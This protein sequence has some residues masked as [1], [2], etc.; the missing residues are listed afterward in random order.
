MAV[1]RRTLLLGG[2][3]IGIGIPAALHLRWSSK[4]FTRPGYSDAPPPAGS[5][6][7][8]SGLQT[9][10]PKAMPVA[11][12]AADLARIV[13][14]SPAPIRAVGSGHS[15]APLVPSD[16]TIVDI[17]PLAGVLSREQGK[18]TVR[19]AAGTRLAQA[20][21]ELDALGLAFPNLPDIDTQTLAG[22]FATGTHGTGKTLPALH[23]AIRGCTLVT[24]KG[25]T[26]TLSER[27]NAELLPAA[28]V[29]LGSLGIA[30]AFDVELVD[31]FSLNRKV[32][33][34]PLETLLAKAPDLWATHRN[35]EFY[36]LP[37]TGRV[38]GIAH[39]IVTGPAKGAKADD[40]DETL[41]GLK[42]MR[43]GLGWWP[44]LRRK[45][46]VSQ[47]PEGETENVTAP[48]PELLSTS[49]PTRF[50]E[51]EYYM[52]A[53]QG[54]A[55]VAE[56]TAAIDSIDHAY[57]PMEVR[58]IGADDAWLS[59]FQEP[60]ISVSIHTAANEPVDDLFRIFEPIF[61]RHGG[62]PHWGKLHSL[63]AKELRPLY[64]DFDRFLAAR[65]RLDPE[66]KFV[67][68]HLAGLF[69]L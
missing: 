64:P 43:D 22:L 52:P 33:V 37:H 28:R 61:R 66:G 11:K 44:W 2:A 6:A 46:A 50:N 54:I 9:S 51:M 41:Q 31:Q 5:W 21:R 45:I 57:F 18:K 20:A 47:L 58:M 49:R 30:T 60:R 42:A 25:E 19:I 4:D 68:P 27:E 17:S 69:G 48:S 35:F 65:A 63:K 59:P 53:E 12:D 32:W 67:N 7:N 55:A 14:T 29:S 24:A 26:L 39:D 16:G 1:S 62:R 15:F 23:A 56:A 3:A 40:D 13:T 8:W 34:E 36:Y 38:A 10:T